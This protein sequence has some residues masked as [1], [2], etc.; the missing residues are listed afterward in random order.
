MI[1]KNYLEL[2]SEPR[3]NNFTSMIFQVQ[4]PRGKDCI[5]IQSCEYQEVFLLISQ[6]QSLTTWGVHERNCRCR[7]WWTWKRCFETL[8]AVDERGEDLWYLFANL[9]LLR[10]VMA[11][12]LRVSMLFAETTV[13]VVAVKTWFVRWGTSRAQLFERG[14]R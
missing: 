5:L 2:F 3:V 6:Q 7:F 10:F 14:D 1:E 13:T 12:I 11:F 8:F 9:L 4:I